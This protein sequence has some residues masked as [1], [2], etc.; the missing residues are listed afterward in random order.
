LRH[1]APEIDNRFACLTLS[2][3]DAETIARSSRMLLTSGATVT[4][5]GVEWNENRSALKQWGTSPTLIEPVTGQLLLRN[6]EVAR[7]VTIAPLD[8]RGQRIGAP[9]AATKTPEG[10]RVTL[11]EQVTT[12]YEIE[13]KR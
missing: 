6:L 8:G 5:T 4:N 11:G 10:W 2:A 3:L 7:G 13:V 1:L 12:W 9:V